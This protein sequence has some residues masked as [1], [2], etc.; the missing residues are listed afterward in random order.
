MTDHSIVAENRENITVTAVTD[1]RNFDSESIDLVLQ[2]GGLS[3]RGKDL[4]ITQL[5]LEAGQVMISGRCSSMTYTE[6]AARTA[7]GFLKW[8]VK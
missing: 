1:V 7:G 5:D 3:V 2:E 8:L 6:T 4:R